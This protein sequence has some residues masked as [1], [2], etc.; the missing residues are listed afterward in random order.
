MLKAPNKM[1]FDH[2]KPAMAFHKRRPKMKDDPIIVNRG[3]INCLFALPCSLASGSLA[4]AAII[5]EWRERYG[6]RP[7]PTIRH[8]KCS[9]MYLNTNRNHSQQ[10]PLLCGGERAYAM[11]SVRTPTHYFRTVNFKQEI[12]VLLFSGGSRIQK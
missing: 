9:E 4:A 5:L 8:E 7:T 11:F 1:L 3:H 6:C 2:F 12:T 10:K